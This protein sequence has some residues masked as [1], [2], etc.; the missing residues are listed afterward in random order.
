MNTATIKKTDI[1]LHGHFY[2]PPRENPRTGIIGKQ[3]TAKPYENWN[4][5]VYA[6]CYSANVNSRYLSGV[7]RILSVTNNFEYISFNF[8]ATLLS[9]IQ[10]KH[11]DMLERIIDADKKSM[12]R[13][14][15]GNAIAQG[16][17]HSILP[18]CTRE[19]AKI[20]IAW[21]LEDFKLRF[22]RDSE[23]L[24]LPEAAINPM[25]I[26]LL[27]EFGIK[28]VILSPWQC[29]GIEN[30]NGKIL[31]LNGTAPPYGKP[32]ILTGEKGGT[33]SA[34]F[35]N[36]SLAEG[37][38]F[39]HLL[40]DAD[41]LYQQLLGIKKNE[42]QSL[43]QTATDGEIYGHHEPFGDM[44][45]A[46]LI[47]KVNERDD[48]S[49]TNYASFLEANPA[50]LHAE[51]HEGEGKKGTSWSCSHG[52]SRWYRDCGCHTGGEEG[53]NQKWRTPLKDGLD[54][55]AQNIDSI[56]AHEVDRIFAGSLSAETLLIKYGK[57]VSEPSKTGAFLDELKI[58][59]PFAQEERENLAKLLAGMKN[60]HFSFTS[61]G[62]FFNDIGGLEPRQ[63]ITYAL[64]AID[65]FQGFTQTDLSTPFLSELDK[66]KSNRKQDG[67][68]KTIALSESRELPG[69]VEASLFFFLN[70]KV[71]LK[72]DY[73]NTYGWYLLD[74]VIQADYMAS[75]MEI[76]NS[77]SLC[78]YQCSVVEVPQDSVK[79]P[80]DFTVTILETNTGI[81]NVYSVSTSNIPAKMLDELFM[82][83][84]RSI[85]ILSEQQIEKI[86]L[87]IKN[88]SI[89]AK[90]SPYLPMGTLYLETMG[91]CL[92]VIKYLFNYGTME[93]WDKYKQSFA[94]MLD[95]MVKHGKTPEMDLIRSIT[96]KKIDIV[97]EKINKE[98]LSEEAVRFITEFLEMI[99]N[100]KFQPNL[101][102]IQ[103][104]LYPYLAHHKQ[105]KEKTDITMV[106]ALSK[107]LNFD[108]SL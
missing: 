4:E 45:L 102:K 7:R 79:I 9:W 67:T 28:F 65:L 76:S 60:K 64:R 84:D 44:A 12:L 93:I 100:F 90:T 96:E 31:D 91:S 58:E 23:G 55:L 59:Y 33:V 71:A 61:C 66:A 21:G 103:N 73:C 8:G 56:F 11:P 99:R 57:V 95:F 32:F 37:I 18:L 92:S 13:L 41:N 22:G 51:L 82:E 42:Q 86:I 24:W 29:K 77:A 46:A 40:R 105:P 87:N 15:H 3:L 94:Q 80:H 75:S 34:F 16:F 70:R 17:N 27:S 25:V 10:E 69:E 62:W 6:D 83:I 36:P 50:I 26:D 52:V 97:A 74:N 43:I 72:Q 30:P 2:Q 48:F 89:L 53:W 54:H 19:D 88:Y 20:Q 98:G 68:G 14:G 81:H 39:G 108:L 106:N 85:C 1:I 78:S 63:N 35:Y 49:F 5:R 47:R 101:T 107:V 104:A 38:S